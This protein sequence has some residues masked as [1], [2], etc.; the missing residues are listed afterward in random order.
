MKTCLLLLRLVDTYESRIGTS[1]FLLLSSYFLLLSSYLQFSSIQNVVYSDK[2]ES[3][4][5]NNTERRIFIFSCTCTKIKP[6]A[7]KGGYPSLFHQIYSKFPFASCIS[8][9][10]FT[11]F[12]VIHLKVH[13]N[14][15]TLKSV[16][17][18]SSNMAAT[19]HV[20]FMKTDFFKS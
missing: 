8:N 2:Y 9:T 17:L 11:I 4:E 10:S 3:T 18:L 15:L 19:I 5:E 16:R 13:K 14:K 20:Y 7:K 6:L 1:Y 12:Y